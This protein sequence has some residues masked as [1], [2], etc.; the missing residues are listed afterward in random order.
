MKE[1]HKEPSFLSLMFDNSSDS[2]LFE[3]KCKYCEQQF[4]N[5]ADLEGHM[6]AIHVRLLV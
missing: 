4:Q 6:N 1:K 5:E 2:W 3:V